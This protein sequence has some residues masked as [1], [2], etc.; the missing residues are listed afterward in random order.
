M[1]DASLLD[2]GA[3]ADSDLVEIAAKNGAVPDGGS[4]VDGDL[5]GE[6]DVGCHVGVD[7]DLGEPLAQGDDPPLASV[8]PFHAIWVWSYYWFGICCGEMKA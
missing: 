5:T 2:V 1:E 3:E 6:N 4:V 7:G 8:V